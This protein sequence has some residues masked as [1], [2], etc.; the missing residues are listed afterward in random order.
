MAAY[1]AVRALNE[2]RGT[3]F[4]T[5]VV[6]QF[7]RTVGMFP[8]GSVIE[9]N[10]GFIGIVLEQNA[11]KPLRPK[12]MVLLDKAHQPLAKPKILDMDSGSKKR[13][14]PNAVWI[15][16]GYEHGAFGVDPAKYFA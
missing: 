8:T 4:Q 16:K 13:S 10:N 12:I 5:E 14:G 3:Q 15:E 9:L 1:D 6:E 2:M 7:V 11:S